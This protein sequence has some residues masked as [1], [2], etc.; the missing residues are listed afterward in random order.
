MQLVHMAS[1]APTAETRQ[2]SKLCDTAAGST[3]PTQAL[4]R[5]ATSQMSCELHPLHPD[6]GHRAVQCVGGTVYR[7]E[8][9][10]IHRHP[11]HLPRLR[12]RT[13]LCVPMTENESWR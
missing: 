12:K 11:N 7:V 1:S 8:V 10:Q 4:K 13:T 2:H 6:G 5:K 3:R 9:A